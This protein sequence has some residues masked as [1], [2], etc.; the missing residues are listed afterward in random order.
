MNDP[1]SI[2]IRPAT[3]IQ[4]AHDRLVALLV[5]DVPSPFGDEHLKSVS[6][7]ASVLCWVLQHNHNVA[8]AQNLAEIDHALREMGYELVDSG[9]VQCRD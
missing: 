4:A 8:F 1:L 7:A 2:Q 6:I 3:E 9:K 5:S